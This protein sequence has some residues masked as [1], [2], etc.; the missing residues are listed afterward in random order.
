MRRMTTSTCFRDGVKHLAADNGIVI[1]EIVLPFHQVENR[2]K[3][4]KWVETITRDMFATVIVVLIARSMWDENDCKHIPTIRAYYE[5][6]SD[7]DLLTGA[8]MS[9]YHTLMFILSKL[10]EPAGV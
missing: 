4:K 6:L 1:N 8:E 7:R 2:L 9:L 10:P 5:I 3:S